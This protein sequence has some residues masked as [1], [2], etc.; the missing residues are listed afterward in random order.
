MIVGDVDHTGYS[1][2]FITAGPYEYDTVNKGEV[3]W[4]EEVFLVVRMAS[5][6]PS[7]V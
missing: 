3:V 5:L 2:V 7:R 6:S 4:W 1:F